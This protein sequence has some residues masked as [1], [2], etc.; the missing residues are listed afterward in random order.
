MGIQIQEVDTRSAPESLLAEMHEYYGPLR[1]EELPN[2]PPVPFERQAAD[3]KNYREDEDVPR[4]LLRVDGEIAAIAVAFISLDQNLE[5]AFAR[6]HVRPELRRQGLGRLLAQP[7][8]E[9][10]SLDGRK[11]LSTYIIEGKPEGALLERLGLKSAYREKRSRLVVADVDMDL[12]RTWIKR[13]SERASEYEL[14]YMEM[15]FPEEVIDRY[16]ELQFQMNTAPQED[17]EQDDEVVT[18]K[19]W[20]DLEEKMTASRHELHTCVAIHK[21]TGDFVGSTT[22][23]TDK[24]QPDQAWQWETVV[25]P[26]HRN[27]GLGRWLKAAN[28]VKV[29][30]ARPL[31]DRIDA[32]NAK[33]NEP[34]LNINIEMGFKQILV[35]DAWQGD[36][37]TARERLGA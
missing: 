25:H 37:E 30:E 10:L 29:L 21:S 20:R 13:A 36:L 31:V 2:D 14:L 11:R 7:V 1:A 8:L 9:F 33:S 6:I 12:M 5:N 17:F 27:K 4:W 18:P 3:W 26:D 35:T 24:L 19:I 15:P 22:L 16:C 34:M 28:I 23:N 32:W